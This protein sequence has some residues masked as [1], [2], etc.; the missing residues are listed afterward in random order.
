MHTKTWRAAAMANQAHIQAQ[1]PHNMNGANAW[2]YFY[3]LMLPYL[4][5]PIGL[6]KSVPWPAD[7]VWKTKLE[8]LIPT[9]SEK[10][11]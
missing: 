8:D 4:K 11:H 3:T 2:E 1:P 6:I 9:Y 10:D 7:L 5:A